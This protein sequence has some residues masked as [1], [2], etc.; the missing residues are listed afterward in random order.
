MKKLTNTQFSFTVEE[1]A[2]TLVK[3]H[4]LNPEEK[5]ETL[6]EVTFYHLTSSK[7]FKV[8]AHI[9]SIN[10]AFEQEDVRNEKLVLLTNGLTRRLKKGEQ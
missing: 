2:H 4:P 3:N 5:V 7:Y 10:E 6:R 8:K 9:N 1:A